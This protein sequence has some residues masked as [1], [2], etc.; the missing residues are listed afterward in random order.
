MSKQTVLTTSN[1]F[2]SITAIAA[3]IVAIAA[4]AIGLLSILKEDKIV[5]IDS[6]KLISN[7][8]RAKIAKL[9]YEK[10]ISV[11]KANVDTLA[12]ELNLAVQKYQTERTQMSERE[13]RL[14]EELLQN[15]QKQL[16]DYRR[17]TSENITK[18]DQNVTGKVL[19]EVNDFLKNF[20]EENGYDFILGTTNMG[21]IVY[22]NKVKDVTDIAL[23]ELNRKYNTNSK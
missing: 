9:E 10:K 6:I 12:N 1:G 2:L 7:F 21:N 22:A 16:D 13:R 23:K 19:A 15:K 14:T 17:A 18:E 4:L 5:Y 20:G 3:M 8:Q 11:W